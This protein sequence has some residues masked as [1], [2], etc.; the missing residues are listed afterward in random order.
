MSGVIYM[1]NIIWNFNFRCLCKKT[2]HPFTISRLFT[3][4][5]AINEVNSK[6]RQCICDPG[7][8]N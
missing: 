6:V 8:V 5:A 4:N 1:E 7:Y 3:P 2:F